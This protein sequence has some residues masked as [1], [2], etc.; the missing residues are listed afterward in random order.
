[1]NI[2][3]LAQTGNHLSGRD[4]GVQKDGLIFLNHAGGK[5]TDSYLFRLI[6]F[7]LFRIHQFPLYIPL[8]S[9]PSPQHADCS[10]LMQYFQI[11]AYSCFGYMEF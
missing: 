8:F 6:S 2:A 5:L 11:S 7:Q 1:M 10:L 3:H 9:G 4:T